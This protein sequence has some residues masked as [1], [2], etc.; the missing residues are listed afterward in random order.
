MREKSWKYIVT[1]QTTTAAMAF[2]SL[3]EKENVPGRLIPVPK[4]ISSGC[5]LAWCVAYES[6]N[7]VDD[8][9]EKKK[10]LYDKADKVWH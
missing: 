1:F 7:L 2:E 6:A 5:G 3:C 8:L 10:P 4:E 9:I